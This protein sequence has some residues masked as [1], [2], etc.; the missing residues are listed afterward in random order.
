M[1]IE[2]GCDS[3]LNN[4]NKLEKDKFCLDANGN[5]CVNTCESI[6]IGDAV[7]RQYGEDCFDDKVV[8]KEPG[9]ELEVLTCTVAANKR[10]LV[11]QITVAMNETAEFYIK[12][13]SNKEERLVTSPGHTTIILKLENPIP[14]EATQT[15]S[16][17]VNSPCEGKFS[18]TLY[19][20]NLDLGV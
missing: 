14:I 13:D 10:L 17:S 2:V 18:A 20:T 3:P 15:I 8:G 9:T 4:V 16:V 19:G 1:S 12:I 5:V 7:K 6:P 11:N